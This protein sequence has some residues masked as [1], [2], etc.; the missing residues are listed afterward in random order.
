[1][2]D[3]WSAVGAVATV[4]FAVVL[5][6]M[7]LS[8]LVTFYLNLRLRR[9]SRRYEALTDQWKQLNQELEAVIGETEVHGRE[10][11]ALAANVEDLEARVQ[12]LRDA[13]A[14][15]ASRERLGEL[16]ARLAEL[17]EARDAVRAGT[18]RSTE[19]LRK[20]EGVRYALLAEQERAHRTLR[21]TK[22]L[23]SALAWLANADIRPRRSPD[24]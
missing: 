16:E 1:M 17:A 20:M 10:V 11:D 8:R 6:G 22:W 5:G 3:F 19:A 13:P 23:Y 14:T 4:V 15:E 2:N 21:R 18:E 7:L 12:E 24:E 9:I